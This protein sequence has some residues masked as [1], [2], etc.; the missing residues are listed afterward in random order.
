VARAATRGATPALMEPH[1]LLRQANAT[2][3]I[4]FAATNAAAPI[5]A[6]G[7]VALTSP[8]PVLAAAA[9]LFLLQAVLIG[10]SRDL[11][12]ADVEPAPWRERLGEALRHVNSR[13]VLR[14]LLIMETAVVV[15]ATMVAPIEVVL[16]KETLDAGDVGY[17]ALAASWGVG[18]L[19]G[20][21]LFARETGRPILGLI[22]VATAA[23]GLGY[24]GMALA[25]GIELA[26]VAAAVGGVGNGVQWVAVITA[27]QEAT[28]ARF[29]ARI[30]GLTEVIL[31][32]A[33][34]IGFTFGGAVTALLSP[35]AA[36]AVAGGGVLVLL[37]LGAFLLGGRGAAFESERAPA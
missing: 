35:R 33:P 22:A 36:F 31:T 25:P 6:G 15:L 30:A 19:V 14:T 28:E 26:C 37:A 27:V 3:N 16:A 7:L 2:L 24:V 13:P 21:A 11:P 8:G 10:T 20:S 29:Q 1:G 17:G 34:G 32:V 23:V 9:G 4:G 12:V 18:M 5:A